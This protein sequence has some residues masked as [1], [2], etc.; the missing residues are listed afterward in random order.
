MGTASNFTSNNIARAVVTLS[1]GTSHLELKVLYTN[2][3]SHQLRL[4]VERN[5]ENMKL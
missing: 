1:E 5:N 4:Y 2:Q 3:L